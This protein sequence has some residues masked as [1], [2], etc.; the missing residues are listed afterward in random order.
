MIKQGILEIV[1]TAVF[2]TLFIPENLSRGKGMLF[3][4][5]VGQYAG[6]TTKQFE[7][8]SML[9]AGCLPA[10]HK[11]LMRKITLGFYREG[12][13][14]IPTS[15][16]IWMGASFL[17][18][19]CGKLLAQGKLVDYASE[20]CLHEARR[21]NDC[22]Y[23]GKK[24]GEWFNRGDSPEGDAAADEFEK[25]VKRE[26]VWPENPWLIETLQPFLMRVEIPQPGNAPVTLCAS[27]EGYLARAVV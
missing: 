19:S 2:D 12:D 11:F 8:T 5:P 14:Y 6:R 3:V 10:P 7:D 26:S 9:M 22:V 1:K 4:I 18:E 25:E 15:H 17:L 13:V 20:I 24:G 16:R 21:L 23:E 27:L